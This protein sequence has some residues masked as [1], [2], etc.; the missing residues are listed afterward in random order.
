MPL[1]FNLS[2]V[3]VLLKSAQTS[4]AAILKDP[5][6]VVSTPTWQNHVAIFEQAGFKV[7]KYPYYD[8]EN[9]GVDFPAMLKSLSGLKENTVV[10]LHACSPQSHRL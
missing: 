7:G 4:F 8:K 9:N 10:I 6:A 5:E 1:P 2:A 3:P